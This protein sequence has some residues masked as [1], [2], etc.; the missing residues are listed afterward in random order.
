LISGR[1]K[2][3]SHSNNQYDWLVLLCH[4]LNYVRILLNCL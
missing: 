2:H 1:L 4:K 3:L